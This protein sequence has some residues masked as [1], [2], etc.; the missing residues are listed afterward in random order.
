MTTARAAVFALVVIAGGASG[1]S[2]PGPSNSAAGSPC[3]GASL[4][5]A[6]PTATSPTAVP[7]GCPGASDDASPFAGASP[8]LRTSHRAQVFAGMAWTTQ[9][10]RREAMAGPANGVRTTQDSLVRRLYEAAIPTSVAVAPARQS[11]SDGSRAAAAA[12]AL[13]EIDDWRRFHLN[14]ADSAHHLVVLQIAASF[15]SA[16]ESPLGQGELLRALTRLDRLN[17]ANESA[18]FVI[19]NEINRMADSA[20]ADRGGSVPDR[21][22]GCVLWH[23]VVACRGPE[24]TSSPAS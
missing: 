18:W 17:D 11:A 24:A 1:Q 8:T 22:T 12:A 13:H 3:P 15:D 10:L 7:S 21:N 20:T 4:A 5:A 2:A 6:S 14:A 9:W 23:L 19:T 16:R